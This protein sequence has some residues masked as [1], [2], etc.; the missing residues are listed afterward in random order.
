VNPAALRRR[1]A[2]VSFHARRF[3]VGRETLHSVAGKL[4]LDLG[5][6]TLTSTSA[7]VLDGQLSLRLKID[8][9]S[10]PPTTA[11]NLKLTDLQLQQ[12]NRQGKGAPPIE[13]PLSLQADLSGHGNSPHQIAASATGAVT[14]VL[15]TGTLRASLAELTGIDLRGLG[16][17][18]SKSKEEDSIRCGLAKFD[19][20]SGMLTSTDMLL[21]TEPVLISGEGTVNLGTEELDLQLTGHPK[22]VRILRLRAPVMIRGSL[23]HPRISVDAHDSKLVLID[24]GHTKDT[25]CAA[26][27]AADAAPSNAPNQ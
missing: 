4:T 20:H 7:N 25:D 23:K 14:A 10:D 8:A 9:R 24:R 26:L 5:V 27:L 16:L 21:D 22:G 18:L 1:D 2:E 11:V 13:G 12:A 6:L 19:V 17:L 3:D 15:P